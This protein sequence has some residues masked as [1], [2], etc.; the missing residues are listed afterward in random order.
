VDDVVLQA[1]AR[2]PNV[3]AVY[4]WLSLDRRGCWRLQG[5][6][7]RHAGLAAFISRNYAVTEEGEWF[8]QNGPQRVFVTL[9]YT[10]WVLR[11]SPETGLLCHTGESVM[12]PASVWLDEGGNVLIGFAAGVG[13]VCD[14]DLPA[15]VARFSATPRPGP[16]DG[17]EAIQTFLSDPAA[18]PLWMHLATGP[19]PVAAIQSSQVPAHFGF[20]ATPE[21]RR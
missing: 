17:T 5:E 4:G 15:L 21:P 7:V 12:N 9:D 11:W 1:L 2:W 18:A 14:R 16:D 8:F 19:L 3:P 20:K 10:P 6:P 13:L